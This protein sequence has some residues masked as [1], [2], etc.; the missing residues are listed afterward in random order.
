MRNDFAARMGH[1]RSERLGFGAGRPAILHRDSVKSSAVPNQKQSIV[2]TII[3]LLFFAGGDFLPL[4]RR[5]D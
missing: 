5:A 3:D 4:C 1:A 2:L